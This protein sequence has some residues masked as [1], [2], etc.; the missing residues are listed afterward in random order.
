VRDVGNGSSTLF[1]QASWVDGGNL[2][3][4]FNRQFDLTKNKHVI[5]SEIFYV[6]WS[7]N[8]EM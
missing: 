3:T 1:W 7:V 4:W 8:R 5:V 2:K 6:G